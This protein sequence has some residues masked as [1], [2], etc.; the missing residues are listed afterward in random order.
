MKYGN[1]GKEYDVGEAIVLQ[2]DVGDCMFVIQ[3]GE[4][5]VFHQKD[6]QIV[7]LTILQEG[8]FFG[9]IPLFERSTRTASVRAKGDV[10]L[11]TVD[12]ETLLQRIHE[13]PSLAYR[14]LQT[15]SQRLLNLDSEVVRLSLE[16]N[17]IKS[18]LESGS[19]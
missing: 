8:E 16:M 18:S 17:Q 4:V 7:S 5:E 2:G 14:I 19:V 6:D 9:E 1:L 10:R 11:L 3:S 12:N 13:D 15:L